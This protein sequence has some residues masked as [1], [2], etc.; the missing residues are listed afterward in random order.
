VTLALAALAANKGVKHL[1]FLSSISV[2]GNNNEKPFSKK[3]TPK[4]QEPYA[5]SK[6]EDEQCLL[7]LGKKRVCR[8]LLFASLWSMVTMLPAI[9][10]H[11]LICF[12]EACHCPWV[13]YPQ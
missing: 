13:L 2:N 5:I 12:T 1:V 6:N 8:W 3:D 10:A 11:W 4:P 9:L 7:V